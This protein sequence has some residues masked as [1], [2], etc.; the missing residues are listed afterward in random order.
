MLF[1]GIIAVDSEKHADKIS[2]F[3]EKIAYIFTVRIAGA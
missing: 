3:F 1:E 2:T